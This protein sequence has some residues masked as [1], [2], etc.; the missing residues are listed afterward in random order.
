MY[1]TQVPTN[2]PKCRG[3]AGEVLDVNRFA[4]NNRAVE[5]SF[6]P[7]NLRS[8]VSLACIRET[9]DFADTKLGIDVLDRHPGLRHVEDLLH[10]DV[11]ESRCGTNRA[12]LYNGKLRLASTISCA[13][14][15]I[16]STRLT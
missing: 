7:Q 12:A 6:G 2:L 5:L 15:V 11:L 1:L 13:R 16:R 10:F 4:A 14:S 9:L 3:G 8:S